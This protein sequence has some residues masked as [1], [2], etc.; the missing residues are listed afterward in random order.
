[1]RPVAT[2]LMERDR[3]FALVT[4]TLDDQHERRLRQ[5]RGTVEAREAVR[6]CLD[7]AEKNLAEARRLRSLDRYLALA[8]VFMLGALCM[9][10]IR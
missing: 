8:A 5:E 2:R 9:G 1:M 6:R 3:E 7:V 10:L 4:R